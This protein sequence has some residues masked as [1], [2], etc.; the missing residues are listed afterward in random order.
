MKFIYDDFGDAFA[1]FFLFCDLHFVYLKSC[2]HG[3][4]ESPL[5]DSKL[6]FELEAFPI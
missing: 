2:G 5:V 4:W 1:S 3:C 6:Y